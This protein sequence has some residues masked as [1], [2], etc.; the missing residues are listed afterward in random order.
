MNNTLN[1]N[2]YSQPNGVYLRILATMFGINDQ[3]AENDILR[4]LKKKILQIN[5][6]GLPLDFFKMFEVYGI[7]GYFNSSGVNEIGNATIVLNV[8]IQDLPASNPNPIKLF[9]ESIAKIKSAGVKVKVNFVNRPN[10]RLGSINR[11]LPSGDLGYGILQADNETT[12]NGG[13]QG[14]I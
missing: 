11:Q 10:F 7:S 12:I 3:H 5:S 2:E 13:Y 1:G 6:R 8:P 14:T 4:E 9:E